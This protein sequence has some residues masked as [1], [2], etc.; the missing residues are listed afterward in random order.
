MALWSTDYEHYSDTVLADCVPSILP[1]C[2]FR[3]ISLPNEGNCKVRDLAYNSRDV[4]NNVNYLR[5]LHYI[6]LLAFGCTTNWYMC[7][8]Y[9]SVGLLHFSTGK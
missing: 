3:N 7:C 2:K 4:V 5:Y 8:N 9:S 6:K 1:L